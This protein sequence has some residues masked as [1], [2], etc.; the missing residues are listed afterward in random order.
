MQT[1]PVRVLAFGGALRKASFNRKLIALAA[2]RARARGAEVD[3]LDLAA[4]NM[5]L[6]DGDLEEA[7]GLPPGAV[8]LRRRMAEADAV[9]ISTPEYNGPMPGVLKNAIDWSSRPP[10]QPWRGKVGLAIAA[11][12]GGFGGMRALIDL[13]KLLGILG[14]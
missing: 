5:P 8:E 6:Y 4:L 10:N 7:S 9:I 14:V 11:S 13:R 1:R 2:E 12:P 3:L